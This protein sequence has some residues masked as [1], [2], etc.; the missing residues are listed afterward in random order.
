MSS[1]WI[2]ITAV[3]L[4]IIWVFSGIY[5]TDASIK[6]TPY[7]DPVLVNAYWD[8]FWAAVITW[9][10][11]AI[12]IILV[13]LIII[14][15]SEFFL[16]PSSNESSGPSLFSIIF[17]IVAVILVL[18]TGILAAFAASWIAQSTQFSQGDQTLKICHSDCVIAASLCLTAVGL[19]IIGII[20]FIVLAVKQSR[21]NAKAKELIKQIND[22][23]KRQLIEIK[24]RLD[25]LELQTVEARAQQ[26]LALERAKVITPQ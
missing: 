18:T 14:F 9:G 12:T 26:Q 8:T 23:K 16:L 11:I 25:I 13:I 20:I 19:M 3:I 5:I 24:D 21:R 7:T 15:F 10:L 1:I 2:S 4:I 17:L 6:L 22:E